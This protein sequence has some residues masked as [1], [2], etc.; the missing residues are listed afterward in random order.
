ME[1]LKGASLCNTQCIYIEEKIC[2]EF[3]RELLALRYGLLHIDILS[4]NEVSKNWFKLI[5]LCDLNY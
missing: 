1:I 5:V 3:V 4:Q 2:A